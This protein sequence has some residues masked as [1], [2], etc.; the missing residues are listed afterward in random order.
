MCTNTFAFKYFTIRL[1]KALRHEYMK[2]SAKKHYI[3][4][5]KLSE[6]VILFSTFHTKSSLFQIQLVK[7]KQLFMK[8]LVLVF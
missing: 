4:S 8:T 3:I 5:E 6:I 2:Y 7:S 1:L